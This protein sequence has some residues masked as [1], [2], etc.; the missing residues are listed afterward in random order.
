MSS[1]TSTAHYA[2]IS[3][4]GVFWYP[5]ENILKNRDLRACLADFGLS[6]VSSVESQ[7]DSALSAPSQ[8]DSIMSVIC[9]GSYPWMCPKLLDFEAQDHRPTKE[10]DI[11]ALGMLVYEIRTRGLLRKR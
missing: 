2:H 1:W 7:V 6:G 5:Q 4:M 9:G 8:R 3:S 10:S 11:Y